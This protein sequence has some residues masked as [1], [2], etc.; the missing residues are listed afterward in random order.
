MQDVPIDWTFLES[1]SDSP[2]GGRHVITIETILI[3]LAVRLGDGAGSDHMFGT[4]FV[5]MHGLKRNQLQHGVLGI[6]E[7]LMVFHVRYSGY[8]T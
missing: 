5:V 7:A 1:V 3:W 2:C 6:L 4:L 8:L